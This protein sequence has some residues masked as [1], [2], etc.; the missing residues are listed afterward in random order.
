MGFTDLSRLLERCCHRPGQCYL[1]DKEFRSAMLLISKV[2][3]L[4]IKMSSNSSCMSPCRSDYIFADVIVGV[5]HVVSED[6]DQL[7]TWLAVIHRLD[8]LRDRYQPTNR[9]P[10]L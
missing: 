5:R 9:D 10:V 7:G 2:I 1:P 8:D 4:E 3:Y 6:S